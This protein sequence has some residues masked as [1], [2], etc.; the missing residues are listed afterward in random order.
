VRGAAYIIENRG[1]NI[2]EIGKRLEV[3]TGKH[4]QEDV[5][6]QIQR[7]TKANQREWSLKGSTRNSSW[8]MK[9]EGE[10]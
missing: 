9:Q 7:T 8:I 3:I 5:N 4:T 10:G 6:S 1:Q 2:S